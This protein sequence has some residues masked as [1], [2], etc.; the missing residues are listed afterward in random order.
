LGSATFRDFSETTKELRRPLLKSFLAPGIGNLPL[1]AMDTRYVNRWL[2]SASTLNTKR[3][4]LLA[5]RPFLQWCISPMGLIETDPTASIK[6]KIRETGGHATWTDEQIDQF[7][8]YH[9]LGTKPRLALELL[10]GLALRRGD[11]IALGRAHVKNGWVS[12]TQGKNRKRKPVKVEA[13][14]PAELIAAIAACPA[15]PDS[16]TFLTNQW[17]KPFSEDGFT[18]WFRRQI[19]AAGLPRAC[20]AHGLRKGACRTMAESDCTPHEIMAVSGHST[21]REV[22]RYTKAA[23]RKQ[24]AARAR[25]K[26]AS[27]ASATK[28]ESNV[29]SLAAAKLG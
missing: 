7:R 26:V 24:L 11:A 5:I 25:A 3:N 2:E 9:P 18:L 27:A 6:V 19:T 8:N 13:P 20:K 16:L 22:E 4:R 29:V 1:K 12:Y 15:P 10:L 23:N 17:G 21:L 14:L 28:T